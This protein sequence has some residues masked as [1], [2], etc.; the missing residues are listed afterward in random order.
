MDSRRGDFDMID[1]P[2]LPKLWVPSKPAIIRAK[3]LPRSDDFTKGVFAP[4]F[5]GAGGPI[6][7][8]VVQSS[9]ANGATC[10]LPSGSAAGDI[11]LFFDS[12]VNTSHSI[13]TLVTPS[14]WSIISN[15]GY[16]STADTAAIRS[17]IFYTILMSAD[18][19]SGS[20]TGMSTTGS[21]RKVM[22]TFR[23]TRPVNALTI[24]SLNGAGG[25]NA[26]S[27]QTISA[28]GAILLGM[29]RGAGAITSSGTLPTSATSVTTSSTAQVVLY[30]TQTSS[31]T[32]RT[33]GMNDTGAYNTL[34]SFYLTLA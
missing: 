10:T 26:P 33:F 19:S 34:Q 18:I 30:E 29:A 9:N 22:L 4:G 20:V 17:A 5:M 8:T 25:V 23:P 16:D 7:A 31:H 21:A 14:N 1:V 28:S 24:S 6:S 11:C 13:P 3:E 2:P 12:S 15:V 27:S 32:D